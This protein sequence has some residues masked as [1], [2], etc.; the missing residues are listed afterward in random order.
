MTETQRA[1]MD[2]MIRLIRESAEQI[3]DNTAISNQELF[4][5][6]LQKGY[7]FLQ[8]QNDQTIV[9]IGAVGLAYALRKAAAG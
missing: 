1:R 6:L 9:D 8:S 7:Q 5:M 3:T 4:I 2:E